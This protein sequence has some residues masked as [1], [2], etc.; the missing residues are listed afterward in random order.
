MY[1]ILILLSSL[2]LFSCSDDSLELIPVDQKPIT[3]DNQ[4]QENPERNVYF[5]DLH[6]HSKYSFDAFILGNVA[7]PDEGYSITIQ[8]R[9]WSSPIWYK[10]K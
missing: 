1:K 6:V 8:E 7:G 2:L 3:E 4:L 9:A 10:S 5:G